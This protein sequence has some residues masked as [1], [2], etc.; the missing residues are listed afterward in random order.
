MKQRP[1]RPRDQLTLDLRRDP[2]V[3]P[4]IHDQAAV[5]QA[6]ADLLL[7]AL[8]TPVE[9]ASNEMTAE[10]SHEREDHA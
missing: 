9:D 7:G 10:A 8:G 3:Q 5:L 1:P 6:I 4:E 2:R